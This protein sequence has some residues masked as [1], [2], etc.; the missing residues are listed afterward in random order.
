MNGY[1]PMHK[2]TEL[3]GHRVINNSIKREH[4]IERNIGSGTIN[5]GGKYWWT[6]IITMHWINA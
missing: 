6:D 2:W 5:V 3:I 1:T 4:T